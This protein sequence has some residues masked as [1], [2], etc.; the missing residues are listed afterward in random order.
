MSPEPEATVAIAARNAERSIA[1]VIESVLAQAGV[2]LRLIVIDDASTD[3]TPDIVRSIVD[4][5]LH[6]VSNASPR[7]RAA[8]WNQA[9]GLTQ[10]AFFVAAG[11]DDVLL[12]GALSDMLDVM[13]ADPRVELAHAYAFEVE[14][15]SDVR[16]EALRARRLELLRRVP[17][18]IDHRRVLVTQGD[19]IGPVPT[20]RRATLAAVG[21]FDERLPERDTVVATALRLLDRG[22]IRLIPRLLSYR[23]VRTASGGSTVP[24]WRRR[25]RRVFAAAADAPQRARRYR[26]RVRTRLAGDGVQAGLVYDWVVDRMSW[27]PLGGGKANKRPIGPRIAYVL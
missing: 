14:D 10:S 20:Y 7:G 5:R 27:W 12:F 3:R 15:S 9:I 4:A 1:G 25:L 16:K 17:P 23:R 6:L 22:E 11:D 19:I 8:C 2:S 13:K 24:R 26:R 18:H 21:G